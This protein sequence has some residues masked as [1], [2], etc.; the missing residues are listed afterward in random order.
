M[1]QQ[2]WIAVYTLKII[3]VSCSFNNTQKYTKQKNLKY[4]ENKY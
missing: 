4:V 1:M 2:F 3:S